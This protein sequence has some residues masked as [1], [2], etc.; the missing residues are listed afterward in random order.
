MRS[1]KTLYMYEMKKILMRKIVWIATGIML[2]AMVFMVLLRMAGT[3]YVDGEALGSNYE[4]FLTDREY[5]RALSGRVIDDG[6]L[7]EM[8]EAYA[9]VPVLKRKHYIATE[10]YQQYAR[11]YSAIRNFA[12]DILQSAGSGDE[13]LTID[14]EGLYQKRQELLQEIRQEFRLTEGET[15]YW[16]KKESE[17]QKPFVYS[18]HDGYERSV[19]YLYSLNMLLML[20]ITVCLSPV[21]TEEHSRR[22]DQLI[23]C[24]RYGRKLLYTAKTAAGISFAAAEVLLF[25]A[26][27]TALTFALYGT[28]GFDAPVQLNYMTSQQ[29]TMGQ[30]VILMYGLLLIVGILYS[31]MVMVIS[32]LCRSNVATIGIMVVFLIVSVF[33]NIPEQYRIA[34]QLIDMLPMLLVTWWGVFDMRLVPMPGGYMTLWQAAVLLYTVTAVCLIMLGKRCYSRYEISGR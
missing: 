26:V 11:P 17:L 12:L 2:A 14:A 5:E 28:D 31:V 3:Y 27:F 7:K 32:E 20:L 30:L 8:Q 1:F 23:L 33:I 22:T 21:F 10:E 13:L 29:M 15:A 19:V 9:K 34:A 25:S 6:L 4:M 16:Q 24:S 18:Y